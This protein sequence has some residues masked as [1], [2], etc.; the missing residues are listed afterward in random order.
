MLDSAAT[1]I[2][3]GKTPDL[4]KPLVALGERVLTN[5]VLKKVPGLGSQSGPSK[6]SASNGGGHIKKNCAA[7]QNGLPGTGYRGGRHSDIK[8]GGN[9]YS[10]KRQSHHVPA[11]SAYGSING[12]PVS[13]D[14]KPTIQMDL[15]DHK[16][17]ASYDNKPGAAQYRDTQARLMMSGKAGFAS[18]LAMDIQ[19][20][21][22]KF[23]G[24]YTSAI[25][26]MMAWSKCMGYI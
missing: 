11:D 7:L 23:P 13:S 9:S 3:E 16:N 12:N 18:A 19:D 25:A 21:K 2:T 15:E 22:S 10:P 20:V 4:V 8:K 14:N 5:T 1:W 26:Q 17:T 24:K 6:K